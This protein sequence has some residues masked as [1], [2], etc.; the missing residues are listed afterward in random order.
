MSIN[1]ELLRRFGD[2]FL[3]LYSI[4]GVPLFREG[5]AEDLESALPVIN[6][7]LVML[8]SNQRDQMVRT[9]VDILILTGAA[10]FLRYPR[11]KE[12]RSVEELS[13]LLL[14]EAEL[15]LASR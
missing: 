10:E 9:C 13:H 2:I 11:V 8:C 12:G 5:Q 3:A 14:L 15:D 4:K 6:L 1:R 7:V